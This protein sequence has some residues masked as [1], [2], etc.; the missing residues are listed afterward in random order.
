MLSFPFVVTSGRAGGALAGGGVDCCA[1]LANA[2]APAAALA[3]K[4]R[5]LNDG[6]CNF[7]MEFSLDCGDCTARHANIARITR[8]TSRTPD[9]T[10]REC[11]KKRTRLCI[12]EEWL[13]FWRSGV[14]RRLLVRLRI[15]S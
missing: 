11:M 2:V 13:W 15:S 10:F 14:L 12:G 5:R 7:A 4:P 8:E 6:F 9:D 3:R 1:G